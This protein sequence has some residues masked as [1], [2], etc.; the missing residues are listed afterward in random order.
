MPKTYSIRQRTTEVNIPAGVSII[1]NECFKRC[2]SLERVIIP[3]GVTD[4][5]ESAFESLVKI[6]YKRRH[7]RCMGYGALG[8]PHRRHARRRLG[9]DRG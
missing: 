7:R 4:I 2:I 9:A 8:P 6:T 3:E 1:G 5:G